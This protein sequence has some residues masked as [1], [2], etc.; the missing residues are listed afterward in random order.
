MKCPF[1]IKICSKC[2]ELLVA[3]NGNFN[4]NK[5]SKGGLNSKC[6]KCVSE[7][8][9][10]RY[11]ENREEKL[12]KCKEYRDSHKKEIKEYMIQYNQDNKKKIKERNKKYVEE[13]KEERKEYHKDYY[14]RN[15]E[16]IKEKQREYHK[17]NPEIAFNK[18]NRRRM[19]Q[20]NQ[21]NGI[22]KEQWM[23]MMNFFDWKCAYSGKYLGNKDNSDRTIDH[24]VP[25]DKD[26]E[27][28]IW[29]CV[30]MHRNYNSSKQANDMF[31]WYIQ[32]EFFSEERLNK[33]YKWIEYAKNKYQK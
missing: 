6:K 16:N 31:E 12:D 15:K 30:P 22:T 26:G 17:N 25:L 2:G 27:H 3:Y 23:E 29:N 28:E 11:K 21:G 13:H 33:I 20:E 24:I 7:Q 9:K 10:K 4:K 14:E 5:T 1:C 32:Q 8:S 19:N 18:R